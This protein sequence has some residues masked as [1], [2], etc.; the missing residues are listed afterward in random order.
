MISGMETGKNP[1]S[2]VA[3]TVAAKAAG[4]LEIWLDDLKDGKLIAIIDVKPTGSTGNW[5]T[6]SKAMKKVT[7]HHDVFI[8]FPTGPHHTIFV[9]D[10]QF[11]SK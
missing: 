5:K 10:I 2:Q 3:L 4:Q 11:S 9:K 7:G 8:K 6:Y 1:A